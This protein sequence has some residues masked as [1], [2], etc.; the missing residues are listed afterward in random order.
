[1][2]QTPLILYSNSS[3]YRI[4]FCIEGV[5]RLSSFCINHCKENSLNLVKTQS[6]VIKALW[7]N[8][9]EGNPRLQ[10]GKKEKWKGQLGV[11]YI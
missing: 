5:C 4:P 2:K 3:S 6:N 10:R 11:G 7:L 1:M 9:I 8:F